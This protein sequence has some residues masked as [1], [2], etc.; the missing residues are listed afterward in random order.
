[1]ASRENADVIETQPPQPS[2]SASI[3]HIFV[4]GGFEIMKV[5]MKDNGASDHPAVVAMLRWKENAE[6]QSQ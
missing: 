2:F 6:A 3:D 5:A 1:M 4:K